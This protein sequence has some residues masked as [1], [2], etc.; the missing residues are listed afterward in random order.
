[1]EF[2]A[3]TI[4]FLAGGALIAIEVF[5][6]SGI[7]IFFA[8]LGAI[9]VGLILLFKP[10][11]STV[12]QFT[13]FFASTALWAAVLWKPF[14]SFYSAPDHGHNDMIGRNV[15]VGPEGL[16]KEKK[17]SVKWSGT[18]MN[19]RLSDSATIENAEAGAE[20]VI[21][22]VSGGTLEVSDKRP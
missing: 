1:M 6:V 21:L 22:S 16:T 4:W 8:G 5:L 19:A 18:M 13:W 11:Y 7:G 20:L 12:A 14:K 17:G 9:T 10:D 2:D 15:T 3:A